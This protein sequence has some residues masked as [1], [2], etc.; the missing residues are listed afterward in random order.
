MAPPNPKSGSRRRSSSEKA[1]RRAT[2]EMPFDDEVRARKS[3]REEEAI[4]TSLYDAKQDQE[5]EQVYDKELSDPGFKPLFLYVEKGPGQGQ[6]V[7]IR[8]GPL[9][10][11]RASISDLR[12]QDPSISRRHAQLTRLGERLYIKDLGSQ[13]GTFVNKRKVAAELEIFAGDELGIG[14]AVI[15]LRG[16]TQHD[17]T[18]AKRARS[19]VESSEVS[20]SASSAR[21]PSSAM[22]IGV[23]AG[24]AGFALATV[25]VVVAMLLNR[26][27]SFSQLQE[28]TVVEVGA[29]APVVTISPSQA[30]AEAPTAQAA[31]AQEPVAE[32]KRQPPPSYTASSFA[33]RSSPTAKKAAP[34]PTRKASPTPS[35]KLSP[36]VKAKILA[37]YEDG[38]LER[39]MTL[40]EDEG[41]DDLLEKL[42]RFQSS[43]GAGKRAVAQNDGGA[44][45]SHFN[46]ALKLDEQISG[47][48]GKQGSAIRTELANL[49][50][51][52][53]SHHLDQDNEDSARKAFEKA[54]SYNPQHAKAKSQLAALNG[55]RTPARSAAKAIDDAWGQDEQPARKPAAAPSKGAD[56]DRFFDD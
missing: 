54:L 28:P 34:S 8:Q 48:W 43:F 13:N 49:W 51:L 33:K 41:A 9:M 23:I 35:A 20:G 26:G 24:L 32:P 38:N 3:R 12:L 6:L 56:L 52:F 11:G 29:S 15:K 27:P 50:A 44:A 5:L 42:G 14:T 2:L 40:A 21:R 47:G 16:P 53:G 10:V 18:V 39:A 22:R 31:R 45:I 25:L 4:P 46:Q 17:P 30:P 36:V 19:A 55:T 37:A 1:P 7:T